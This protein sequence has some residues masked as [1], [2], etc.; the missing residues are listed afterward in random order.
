MTGLAMKDGVD[1]YQS[2]EYLLLSK[3]LGLH[4]YGIFIYSISS[5]LTELKSYMWYRMLI[6]D[7][8]I[9]QLFG[10]FG[11]CILV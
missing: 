10:I 4:Q 7:S 9:L 3:E 11:T 1:R 5:E 2:K 6:K 8:L